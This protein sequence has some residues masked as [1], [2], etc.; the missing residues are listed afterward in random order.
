MLSGTTAF[1]AGW[2]EWKT[3]YEEGSQSN[4]PKVMIAFKFGHCKNGQM[5][6]YSFWRTSN[7]YTCPGAH[8]DMK[9]DWVD[10]SG[11]IKTD[12]L[13][14]D[15]SRPRVDEA[16]GNWFPGREVVKIYYI[17]YSDGE[18]AENRRN[19]AQRMGQ[20]E[21]RK[22][23]LKVKQQQRE[24]ALN[25]QK[26]TLQNDWNRK[27]LAIDQQ[28][29]AEMDAIQSNGNLLQRMFEEE[30]IKE[31]A[32]R[33]REQMDREQREIE[34][35]LAR[36]Q[37]DAREEME[38]LQVEYADTSSGGSTTPVYA[39]PT[40]EEKTVDLGQGVSI[41]LVHIPSGT[42]QMG[43]SSSGEKDE[44]PVHEVTISQDFW[45][46]KYE[47][48]QAQWQAVMGSNPSHFKGGKLPV[49]LVQ[50]KGAQG[51]LKRV[52]GATN[53]GFRLPTEAEW[54]YACR[55]GSTGD[56]YGALDDGDDVAWYVGN[57]GNTTHPVGLRQPNAFGLHDML[58]NVW[59]WCQDRY[60][61]SYYSSS[62]GSNPTGPSSGSFRVLRG[63]GWND[64]ATHCRSAFRLGTAPDSRYINIGFRVVAVARTK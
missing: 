4:S 59:E 42:F 24:E 31:E 50:W 47:V 15:M 61:D 22:R 17:R 16:K 62:P 29:R 2:S 64:I 13:T 26:W 52:N 49:E 44:Q 46:G 56:T 10:C 5:V 58:G 25:L 8:L 18:E 35:E 3:V 43:S 27:L 28:Q 30:R 23:E 34:E 12:S 14:I 45:M 21:Q 48:T 9:F 6:D 57:S 53:G 63:G 41:V 38:R 39:A 60:G 54:E 40:V 32:R 55:A 20:F 11:S 33:K 7:T 36:E 51:F 19:Q 37:K 1:A